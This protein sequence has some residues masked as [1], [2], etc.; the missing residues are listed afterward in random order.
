[1]VAEGFIRPEHRSGI[2]FADQP[3][4]LLDLLAGFEPARIHKWIDRDL[5]DSTRALP[6]TGPGRPA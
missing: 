5:A 3:D 1:M 4:R 2:Y 6:G